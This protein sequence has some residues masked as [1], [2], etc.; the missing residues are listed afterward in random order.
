MAGEIWEMAQEL[1]GEVTTVASQGDFG[2]TLVRSELAR[3][4]GVEHPGFEPRLATGIG[5]HRYRFVD[6][7]FGDTMTASLI[8]LKRRHLPPHLLFLEERTQMEMD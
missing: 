2:E 8:T 7:V 6:G 5:R 4:L 1:L 3:R